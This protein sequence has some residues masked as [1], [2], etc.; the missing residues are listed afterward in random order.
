MF[1]THAE[2]IYRLL[3]CRNISI[4]QNGTASGLIAAVANAAIPIQASLLAGPTN[5]TS[6]IRQFGNA[7]GGLLGAVVNAAVPVQLNL[8]R[9]L[10]QQ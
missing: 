4:D 5:Q 8:G 10:V 7:T 1:L 9:K 2:L 6:T 3:C